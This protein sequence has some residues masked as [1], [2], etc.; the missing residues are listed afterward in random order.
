MS[1][2]SFPPGFHWGAATASFQ[3]EGSTTADGRTDSIWDA[4]CRV[5]GAVVNGDSGEPGADHYRRYRSDV[6]LMKSLG[7]NAY[8]FSTAWP[9]VRPDGGAE[10]PKGLDFYERLVD[11]LLDNGITPWITLYHWDLPQALEAEGGWADRDT[12]FR[13]ADY[14]ASVLDRLGD[15]VH[16]WITLNEPWCSAFLGYAVGRH[17]PGRTSPR[18]ALAAVHHL[19]LA[20]GLAVDVIRGSAAQAQAGITLNLFPVV[21]VQPQDAEVARRVDGLQNRIFLDPVLHGRYPEDVLAD[22]APHGFTD[23]VLD[24]DVATISRTVDFLGVNYYRDLQVI[25]SGVPVTGPT[26]WI[27][28]E[29]ARFPARGRPLTDMGWEVVPEGLTDL[30]LSLHRQRPDLPV[31]ITENGAAYADEV[32]DGQVHDSDRVE[33]LAAHLRAVHAAISEGADVRGYF[34]WSLLDNFEW[35][36]GYAKR[37]G[38]VHVDYATQRRTPKDSAHWYARVIADHGLG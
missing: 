38:I 14:A 24:G 6:E 27:G 37:F 32:V 8:R 29:T 13:F 36:E 2:L 21:A 33:F 4:L 18:A 35:A 15:R 17:A 12:A 5:P 31:Y 11:C 23:Y 25:D 34:C 9:R 20:H 10:N 19:M 26:E 3:V 7:L 16:H 1:V 22:L 28:A 30:L